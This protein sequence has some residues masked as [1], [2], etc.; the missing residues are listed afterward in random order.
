MHPYSPKDGDSDARRT[1][2]ATPQWVKVFALVVVLILV[3]FAALHLT[4]H[5]LGDHAP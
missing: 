4:G 2:E 3:V 5:S 1:T